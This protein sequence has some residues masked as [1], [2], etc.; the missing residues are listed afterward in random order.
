[1]G[2]RGRRNSRYGSWSAEDMGRALSALRNGDMG[3]NASSKAY[4]VPKAT[5]KR[6]LLNQNV[7]ANDEVKSH[8]RSTDLPREIEDELVQHILRLEEMFFGLTAYDLRKL[9][10]QIAEM[11]EL[12]HRFNKEK[13]IAGK[14][15]Y[16]RFLARHPEISL[17]KPEATSLA[18]ATGFNKPRVM[19]FFD[20]LERIVDEKK[21]TANR[22]FN[23]DE[24][25]LSTVQKPQKILGRKGKHQI[26]A[27][28]SAE[29]GQN[30]TCMFCVSATGMYVPPMLIFKRVS[31]MIAYI[32]CLKNYY[33]WLLD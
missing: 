2:K 24:T 30:T 31:T 9:A 5:L 21:L 19:S 16:Y 18:R 8:G 1:M 4:G 33:E 11:N 32:N 12:Q 22:I 23:A 10:F 3:L 20:I 26:G 17:R 25:G 7:H 27:I 29:R 13:E 14:K 28:T 15:W 6:H